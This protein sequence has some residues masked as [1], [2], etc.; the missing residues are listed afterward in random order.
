MRTSEEAGELGP[1]GDDNAAAQALPITAQGTA[2]V[3]S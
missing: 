3:G 1:V 2:M